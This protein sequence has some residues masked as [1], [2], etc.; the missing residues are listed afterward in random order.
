MR[1]DLAFQPASLGKARKLVADACDRWGLPRLGGDAALVASELVGNALRHAQPPLRLVARLRPPY[2][3]LV[4]SDGSTTPPE[5]PAV[6]T[7]RGGLR[8]RDRGL[9]LIDA[10][11]VGW[12]SLPTVCGKAVWARLSTEPVGLRVAVGTAPTRSAGVLR[13]IRAARPA[14]GRPYG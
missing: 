1:V 3:H 8:I 11:A 12:G 5:L 4:V 2:L 10:L 9:H 13:T 6:P 14:R 7:R